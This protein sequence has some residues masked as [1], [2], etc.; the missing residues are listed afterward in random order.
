MPSIRRD[1]HSPSYKIENE[2]VQF[3]GDCFLGN[4]IKNVDNERQQLIDVLVEKCSRFD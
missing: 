2:K 3:L 1:S 4:E